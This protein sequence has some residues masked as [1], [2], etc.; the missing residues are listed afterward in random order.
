M[1]F[2]LK[3]ARFFSYLAIVVVLSSLVLALLCGYGG[4][5]FLKPRGGRKD[6]GRW[7]SK[8]NGSVQ[9]TAPP[10]AQTI[11]MQPLQPNG[12]LSPSS[13]YEDMGTVKRYLYFAAV[14]Q[15]LK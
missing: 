10:Q 4:A 14:T 3:Q 12:L 15:P 8:S 2:L 1:T 7:M 5:K 6:K 13:T 11:T 9:P